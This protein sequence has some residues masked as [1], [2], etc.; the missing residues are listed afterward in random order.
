MLRKL[1]TRKSFTKASRLCSYC[2]CSDASMSL[3]QTLTLE[4]CANFVKCF[5]ILRNKRDI[6]MLINAC[7]SAL[8][9]GDGLMSVEQSI[10]SKVLKEFTSKNK[11]VTMLHHPRN[12]SKAFD[13]EKT[14]PSFQI[15]HS[16]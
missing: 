6:Q 3:K 14:E 2:P 10:K 15:P 16:L 5:L 8:Y 11:A 12:R 7:F 1:I 13:M 9:H 4:G